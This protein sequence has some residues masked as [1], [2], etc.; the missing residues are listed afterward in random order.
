MLNYHDSIKGMELDQKP[1]PI[2]ETV[3]VGYTKEQ[4]LR[5][6]ENADREIAR[7]AEYRERW[8]EILE[9]ISDEIT[10]ERVLE[11]IDEGDVND[12]V[13]VRIYTHKGNNDADIK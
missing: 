10:E 9:R 2:P 7:I 8:V 6:I 13:E 12:T 1:V 5:E 3:T 11:R 4:V